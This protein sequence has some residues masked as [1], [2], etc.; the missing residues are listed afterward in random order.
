MIP[1]MS[2]LV[3]LKE[4]EKVKNL[5]YDTNTLR[6]KYPNKIVVIRRKAYIKKDI[7]CDEVLQNTTDLTDYIP[8]GLMSEILSIKAELLFNRIKF[9][10]ATNSI[11]FQYKKIEGIYFIKLQEEMKYLFMN[12][13]PFLATFNDTNNLRY[14][15][16]LGDI[17]IGFY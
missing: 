8:L 11:L 5:K 12:F 15:R 1:N 9:M 14:C 2:G 13:Q 6:K 17:K 4:I 3:L 7:L 10:E 16:L